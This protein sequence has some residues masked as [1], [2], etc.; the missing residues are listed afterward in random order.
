MKYPIKPFIQGNLMALID[1]GA[2]IENLH[3]RIASFILCI[4]VGVFGLSEKA[5]AAE[6]ELYTTMREVGIVM[7][8]I[9][10]EDLNIIKEADS[11]TI[12]ML[13]VEE[14]SISDITITEQTPE[15]TKAE[16][17]EENDI[18]ENDA[19]RYSSETLSRTE[20]EACCKAAGLEFNVDP[21]ILEAL[22]ETE[23]GLDVYAV[24]GNYVGLFQVSLQHS[25]RMAAIG[26]TDI[27]EPLTNARVAAS[28]LSELL[29]ECGDMH[30]ALMRYNMR[31][32]T[33]NNM[34]KNGKISDYAKKI[35]SRAE[36]LRQYGLMG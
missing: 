22:C 16:F 27:W 29:Q 12:D 19:I 28:L 24:N 23:S 15:V 1:S 6:N 35:V 30:Y 2:E 18:P 32:D 4:T 33:A 14:G 9:T 7:A 21:Y 13:S 34:W 5:Y 17:E 10:E 20:L 25:D 11:F 31:A 8:Q 3:L 36:V 26:G